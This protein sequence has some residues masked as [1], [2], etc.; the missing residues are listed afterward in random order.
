MTAGSDQVTTVFHVV[1]EPAV[2]GVS[3][4]YGVLNAG[5]WSVWCRNCQWRAEPTP[6]GPDPA[7]FRSVRK[8]AEAAWRD[9][10]DDAHR[11]EGAPADRLVEVGPAPPAIFPEVA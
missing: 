2:S 11:T 10:Q 3:G 1:P 6:T 9:H 4:P 5:S 7:S 8:S